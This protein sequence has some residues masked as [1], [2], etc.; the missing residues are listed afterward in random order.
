MR[1][2]LATT[3]K[4]I[5]SESGKPTRLALTAIVSFFKRLLLL[6]FFGPGVLGT[7]WLVGKVFKKR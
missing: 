4:Q 6:I 1:N 5:E 2:S 7:A 3:S